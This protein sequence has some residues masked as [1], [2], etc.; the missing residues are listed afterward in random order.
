MRCLRL[1]ILGYAICLLLLIDGCAATN[2][3]VPRP[4]NDLPPPGKAI[5]R[6]QRPS[7]GLGSGRSVTVRDDG[8]PIGDLGPG[9]EL[10]WERPGGSATLSLAPSWMSVR[11][12]NPPLTVTVEAG[13]TYT[14]FVVTSREHYFVLTDELWPGERL[15]RQ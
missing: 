13:K 2:Q 14:Y 3:F 6:V 15:H 8:T 4:R 11:E 7:G 10:A 5:I 1:R 9:G 12:D